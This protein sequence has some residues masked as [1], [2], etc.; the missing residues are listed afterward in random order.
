MA[1]M[2]AILAAALTLCV[3]CTYTDGGE[4]AGS[5]ITASSDS[6]LATTREDSVPVFVSKAKVGKDTRYVLSYRGREVHIFAGESGLLGVKVVADESE[7][8]WNSLW[9]A[10]SP[11]RVRPR[12]HGEDDL[13]PDGGVKLDFVPEELRGYVQ[14]AQQLALHLAPQTPRTGEEAASPPRSRAVIRE[15]QLPPIAANEL[16]IF[17]RTDRLA[18]TQNLKFPAREA[19]GEMTNR[20]SIKFERCVSSVTYVPAGAWA[21]FKLVLRDSHTVHYVIRDQAGDY[22]S[23]TEA[24]AHKRGDTLEIVLEQLVTNKG[25]T[26]SIDYYEPV[27]GDPMVLSNQV[28]RAAGITLSL[29]DA[30][31]LDLPEDFKR[32]LIV[33]TTLL[34]EREQVS[35]Y[36]VQREG[37]RGVEPILQEFESGN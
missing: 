1:T 20:G 16:A 18:V 21:S 5:A 29:L 34:M 13:A 9:L 36:K 24:Y 14:D 4:D 10:F 27:A 2:L 11:R 6:T 7:A 32:Q 22:T 30:G 17:A 12:E 25:G 23:Y 35:D 3:G 19:P 31:V 33:T 28:R 15:V 26:L 37:P 8:S